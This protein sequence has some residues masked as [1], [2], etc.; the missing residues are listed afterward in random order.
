VTETEAGTRPHADETRNRLLEA[1]AT[2][3]ADRGFHG[4]STRDIA[5]AAGLSPA[6]VYVHHRSKED[7]L[8]QISLHGHQ[9]T[10]TLVRGAVAT[11][12]R[13]SAQLVAI[14]GAFAAYHA[15]ANT[16][17]R[18]VNYELAA[19][20]EE[21]LEEILQLRRAIAAEIHGVVERGLSEGAF[22]TP[23]PRMAATAL[24]SLGIDIARWYRDEREWTPDDIAAYYAHLALRMVGAKD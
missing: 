11:S 23:N 10:L 18:V 5:A 15:R 14:V 3:F 21:H 8:H 6:A 24:L 7:L 22:D 9:A 4:T 1:A 12:D 19:L 20:S 2:A 13:P 17:A 16:T